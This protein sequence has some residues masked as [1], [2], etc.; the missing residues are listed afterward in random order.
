MKLVRRK[1]CTEEFRSGG[2]ALISLHN[3]FNVL[4]SH[5]ILM[6]HH[7]SA[8]TQSTTVVFSEDKFSP[9][10]PVSNNVGV[11]LSNPQFSQG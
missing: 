6:T 2:K 4:S 11:G 3:N 5:P 9:T 10:L 8:N 7:I 1:I